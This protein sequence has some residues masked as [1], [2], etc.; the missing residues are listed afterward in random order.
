MQAGVFYD[1]TL[2]N[3]DAF[4]VKLTEAGDTLWTKT[5]GGIGF[6]NANIV[7]QTLDSGFVL[8]GV[9]QSYSMGPASDFYL[10][11]IDKNGNFVWQQNYGTTATEECISGQTTLDGG[12]ILSGRKSNLFHLV[13][14]DSNGNFQWE[15]TYSGTK[16]VCF[17]KQLSDS[18]Y[19]L[20]GAI[21]LAGF[22]DQCCVLKT[23][24]SGGVV[25]QKDY[26]GT[27]NDWLYSIPVILN[28]G[29][30]AISG[31][32]ML[33]ANPIG[34]L[35]KIDSLGNQ[36]WLRTYYA[37]PS[38][39]NYIYDVKLTSDN[40]FIMTG[41]GNVVGQDAWVV[42]V[43]SN[44]CEIAN[45]N[46]GVDELQ[47]SYSKLFLYPNPA[48]SE[49]NISIDGE[50][51][52]DYEVVIYNTLGEEQKFI[53]TNSIISISHL[54]TGV[55]FISAKRLDGQKRLSSKFIKQ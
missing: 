43:D 55:Y 7:C 54:A 5:F 4:V 25:W 23:N 30:M 21:A 44:G 38:N 6:D 39:Q 52:N 27:N 28:D 32:T 14:T 37:N 31:H 51:I 13:K 53:N 24:K 8:M 19:I 22:G 20:T 36:Q 15:Q 46:V 26:G 11:K 33:G 49:I 47:I 40:G 9:T 50:N 16:G 12:F 41:S 48:S 17:V 45:C 35:L 2:T 34:V 42:K 1:S 10:I 3:A 29:S 18:T